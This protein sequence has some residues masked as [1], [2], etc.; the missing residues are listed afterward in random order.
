[1]QNYLSNRVLYQISAKLIYMKRTNLI[2]S[3]QMLWQFS[4]YVCNGFYSFFISKI[5][6]KNLYS[7]LYVIGKIEKILNTNNSVSTTPTKN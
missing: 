7:N 5:C 1:M 2:L 3:D 6:F 4:K